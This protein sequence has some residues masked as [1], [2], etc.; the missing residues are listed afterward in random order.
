MIFGDDIDFGKGGIG[1]FVQ[2]KESRN[3]LVHFVSSHDSIE[4]PGPVIIHGLA[5]TSFY[6]SLSVSLAS[7][8]PD[9]VRG[10]AYEIFRLRGIDKDKRP[11]SFHAWFG[12][13]PSNSTLQ[14]TRANDG[15]VD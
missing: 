13:P 3:S 6:S 4:L 8:C 12:E 7:K 10:V 5:D 14:P 11:H 1:D 9:I 2:L 15:A